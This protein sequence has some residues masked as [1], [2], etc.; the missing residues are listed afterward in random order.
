MCPRGS[1]RALACS[2][3]LAHLDDADEDVRLGSFELLWGLL[4]HLRPDSDDA[5]AAPPAFGLSTPPA[6][7]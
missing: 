6:S 1:R 7:A 5:G 3:A 4:H 2:P